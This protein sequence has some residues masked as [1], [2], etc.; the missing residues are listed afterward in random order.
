MWRVIRG[1]IRTLQQYAASPKTQ[2]EYLHYFYFLLLFSIV[3][4]IIWGGIYIYH[5]NY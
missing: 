1:Y 3:L 2:F 5:G 4:A